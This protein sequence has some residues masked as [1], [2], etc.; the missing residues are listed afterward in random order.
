ME[1]AVTI[2]ANCMKQ[3]EVFLNLE[4]NLSLK[5]IQAY[6]SDLNG[7]LAWYQARALPSITME[8]LQLYLE[9]LSLTYNLKDTTIKRKY[10]SIKAFFNFLVHKQELTASPLSEFG[11]KFKQSKR[12]PKVLSVLEVEKLLNSP[13]EQMKR[14]RTSF[15]KWICIR[16]NAIIEL[17]YV[18]GIRIG[19]LVGIDLENMDLTERTI[20][21][22]GKGRKER[23]L[24]IS[25]NEVVEKIQMWLRVRPHLQPKTNALFINKYG[26]RLSIYSIEDIYATYRD[27]SNISKNSTPHFLRHS[28]ATHLLNNGADLRAVQEILGHSSVSTT[29]I[30]TEVSVERKKEVLNRFNPRNH[31]KL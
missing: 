23:I 20:V 22:L 17:L 8:N 7:V 3:Y 29:Q 14:L 25:S 13:Q 4:R 11:K 27:L 31:L 15:R 10:I 1:L 2:F 24:Y 9:E 6:R 19:E 16:N 30:Y 12:I 21:I 26:E 5:S 28:F 18:I